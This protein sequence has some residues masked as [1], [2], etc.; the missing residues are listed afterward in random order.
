MAF[1]PTG[2]AVI[3]RHDIDFSIAKAVELAVAEMDQES[4][5]LKKLRD[6]LVEGVM[7]MEGA[8]L[9]GHPTARL[10]NHASF[11]FKGTDGASLVLQLD[12]YGIAAST[13]SACSS[14]KQEQSHV[15]RATGV[16]SNWG[17]LRL[18]MGRDS[19][20]SDVDYVLETLPKVL[21]K[22]QAMARWS[23]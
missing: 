22:M 2:A 15:L 11:A 9:T 13:G 8:T 23:K 1:P 7:N 17:S 20:E 21:S 14:T 10:P 4:A 12:S 19:T 6:R 18:T 5:R 16:P 3:L